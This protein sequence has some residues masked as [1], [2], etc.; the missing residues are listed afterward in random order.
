M[1]RLLSLF[2]LVGVAASPSYA[3]DVPTFEKDILPLLKDRCFSCHGNDQMK[4]GL[5]LRTRA[6]LLKGGRSGPAIV[7]RSLKESLLWLNV[8]TDKM[9]ADKR[10]VSDAE[11]DLLRRWIV[12]GAP[13]DGATATIV[14]K[15]QTVAAGPLTKRGPVA[16]V[17]LIDGEIARHL[18]EAKLPQSPEADDAEY[19]RRVY[20]DLNGRIPSLEQTV[21]FLD[22]KATDKRMRLV[23]ELLASPDYGKHFGSIWAKVITAEEPYLRTGLEKWLGD[24]FNQ[25]RPWDALVRDLL[26]ATGK[27]PETAFIMSN[28]D[29]K[30]PQPNKL[31]GATTRLFLGLQLQCAECHNHP[32]VDWKQ[33]DFWSIA[34]FFTNTRASKTQPIEVT[35]SEPPAPKGKPA[36]PP[37]GAVIVLPVSA[38]RGAGKS[39]P[40]KFLNGDQ[41]K[42]DPLG[43]FRPALATWLTARDNPFFADAAANRMWAHFLGRGF[44]NPIDDFNEDNPPTHSAALQ[45]LADEFRASDFDW[46]HL[47][48]CICATKAYQRSSKAVAG[49]KEDVVLYSRMAAKVMS[50]ESLYDSLVHA[51][52]VKEINIQTGPTATSGTGGS[53]S[54][55]PTARERFIRFFNTSDPEGYATEYSHGIP[56]ALSLMNDP[57][58]AQRPPLLDKL[59]KAD[60]KPEKVIDGLYLG[61]LNR[62][63]TPV[64]AK[65]MLD[66]VGR[67]SDAIRGYS[68]V[69][70]VLINTPEFVLIR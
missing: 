28:V 43:A 58:L 48:R 3:A 47:I 14:K 46:K 44:V 57:S 67:Q 53:K 16:I 22:N 61:L 69:L 10:T 32:F 5:D 15:T 7:P 24:Q 49:N 33:T 51:L 9:P 50:P 23:E 63:P 4:G 64:E 31:T 18:S 54:G 21:A 68:G 30:V 60:P 42:L 13:G 6:S 59:V 12:A 66:Y 56:Q 36:P 70:W 35:E 38:G 1:L 19:L 55:K 41:P 39:V 34:A 37:Q 65:S 11:K 17:A 27:G 25:N 20:L 26:T 62:R 2:S 45:A 8:S 52:G 40:A 29:N